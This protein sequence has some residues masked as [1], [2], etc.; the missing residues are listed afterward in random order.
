MRIGQREAITRNTPQFK[1]GMRKSV[2]E[3]RNLVI[4]M[5]AVDAVKRIT[6]PEIVTHPFF[7]TGLLRNLISF[8]RP[9]GP[10]P[11]RFGCRGP[12]ALKGRDFVGCPGG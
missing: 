3:A 2:S 9:S 11:G 4:Q 8:P 10:A 6:Y 1:T 5:L 12:S 7:T